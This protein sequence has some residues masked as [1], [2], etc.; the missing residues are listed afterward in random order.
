MRFSTRNFSPGYDHMRSTLPPRSIGLGLESECS[1]V[2]PRILEYLADVRSCRYNRF[3]PED[4]TWSLVE[5]RW[6]KMPVL[7][8]FFFR[9]ACHKG[10]ECWNV[11]IG[12]FVYHGILDVPEPSWSRTSTLF[13]LGNSSIGRKSNPLRLFEGLPSL[14]FI[15]RILSY[16]LSLSLLFID[17][18]FEMVLTAYCTLA[19]QSPCVTKWSMCN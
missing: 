6:T 12:I 14:V 19:Q 13:F 10:L 7:V 16:S 1:P 17:S 8:W 9:R 11:W 15:S 18:F 5:Q 4:S 3:H 2:R